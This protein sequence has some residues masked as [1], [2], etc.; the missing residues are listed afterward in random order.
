[1]ARTGTSW[2]RSRKGGTQIANALI[3]ST[4]A[5]YCPPL[6]FRLLEP[7]AVA[8]HFDDMP[9][10][11]VLIEGLEAKPSKSDPADE[12]PAIEGPAVT[13]LGDIWDI[14][15]H[16]LICGDATAP[17]TYERLTD[18]MRPWLER[19]LHRV[20]GRSGLAEAIR[21]ALAR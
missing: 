10:I 15:P 1:M 21:Y 11:D 6:A 19:Q 8:V 13:R 5:G 2:R 20:P 14:G 17:E 18:A 7:V 16:R 3:L 4:A 9:E 12:V